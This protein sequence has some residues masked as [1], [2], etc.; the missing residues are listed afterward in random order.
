[1][2]GAHK[3]LFDW[4]RAGEA[5]YVW[6]FHCPE[7]MMTLYEVGEAGRELL[8][9]ITAKGWRAYSPL[10]PGPGGACTKLGALSLAYDVCEGEKVA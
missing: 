6:D 1:M 9:L 3:E 2:I 5:R 4:L 8:V 7:G 10:V